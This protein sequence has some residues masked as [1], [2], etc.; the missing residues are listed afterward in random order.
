MNNIMVDTEKIIDSLRAVYEERGLSVDTAYDLVYA[1]DPA[2]CP[3]RTTIARI[4][5]KNGKKNGF[6]WELS[7]RP[8]A[9]ALLNL[10]DKPDSQVVKSILKLKKDTIEELEE[11]L[12]AEKEKYH[13]KLAAETDKFQKS[14][15]FLK[16][17]VELKDK[18]IDIL[19]ESND[20]LSVTNNKL[21]NQF[22]N[23]PLNKDCK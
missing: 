16:H 9:N 7:L 20:R 11:K 3:S 1:K 13:E 10:D 12:N 6:S 2:N 22:L 4:F 14:L 19:L 5:R 8:V 15:E 17:Q 23:C 21:L 18:R